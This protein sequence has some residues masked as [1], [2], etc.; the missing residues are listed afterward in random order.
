MQRDKDTLIGIFR[1]S[2]LIITY[3]LTSA[4]VGSLLT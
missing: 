1:G 4:F 3:V 2:D